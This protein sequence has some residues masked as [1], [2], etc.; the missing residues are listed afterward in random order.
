MPSGNPSWSRLPRLLDPLLLWL[1]AL[2]RDSL[3][4]SPLS[5]LLGETALRRGGAAEATT[6]LLPKF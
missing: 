6:E 4:L 1:G 5:P 3:S 2:V